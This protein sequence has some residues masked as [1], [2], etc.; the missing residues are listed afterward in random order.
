MRTQQQKTAAAKLAP[1]KVR[2]FNL[3]TNIY[4]LKYYTRENELTQTVAIVTEF[5]LLKPL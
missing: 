3:T 4:F 1:W 5:I 2:G